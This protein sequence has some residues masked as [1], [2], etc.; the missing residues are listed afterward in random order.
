MLFLSFHRP[1]FRNFDA[2]VGKIDG[3][4]IILYVNNC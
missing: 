2:K 4:T 3:I 1:D